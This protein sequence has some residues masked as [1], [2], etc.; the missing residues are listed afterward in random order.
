[1][2]PSNVIVW[3]RSVLRK[4]G[5]KGRTS[6]VGKLPPEMGEQNSK[7]LLAVMLSTE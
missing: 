3:R 1:M 7:N 5:V 4:A 2:R 6:C